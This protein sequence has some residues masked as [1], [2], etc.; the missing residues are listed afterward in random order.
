MILEIQHETVMEYSQPV[1]E[2]LCE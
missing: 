1:S 2:W